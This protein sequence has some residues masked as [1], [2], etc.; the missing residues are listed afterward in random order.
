MTDEQRPQPPADDRSERR[1]QNG[2]DIEEPR[3]VRV[4]RRA[5]PAEPEQ[6]EMVRGAK[7]GSRYAR[8]IRAGERRFQPADATGTIRVTERATAPRTRAERFWRNVRRVAIG[9][10][11]SS[12][13]QESQRLPKLKA[14]AVFSSDALSSSAYATDEILLVLV[15]A[16]TGALSASI[17]IALAIGALLGIVAFSYRQ[18][19][20][21]YPNGG[22]SY[23]VARENLGDVAGLSAAAALSVDYI[24]T[25]SVSVAAGVFAITS[26]APGLNEISVE[27][28]VAFVAIITLL[29]LRG[30][31]ESGT[32]FAIPTYAFIIGFVVL[33]VG[34][35]VRMGFDP[36]LRAH[37]PASGWHAAGAASLSWF[38]VLRAFASGSAALT[39]VEAISN[40]IPAFKKPESKNASITL[41]WM[42]AILAVFF[43][44]LTIL[45]HQFGV[46]HADEVSAPAQV[47]RVV[48]GHTPI[49][50]YI[51]ASTA[52]ILILAANTSYADFPRLASILSRD[53]FLPHQ[54]TF[55]GDR[56]AFSN[57][58]I[59]L[60]V[61]ASVLLVIFDADV[62]R[63]IPLYAFGV[64]VSFTLSQSGM[65]IHHTRL[66]EPGWKGSLTIN[67]TGAIATGV[68]AVII[69]ATKFSEG[70]WISMIAMVVLGILFYQIHRHY[71][72]VD[73][74][75]AI[76]EDA[77]LGPL[78][79]GRQSVLVPVETINRATLQTI[80]YAHSISPSVT[81]LHVTDDPEEGQALRSEWE[82][83]VLDVPLVVIDSPFRSF[84]APVLSYI[85]ALDRADPGQF[86]TVVLPDF[87]TAWPWQRWLHNQSARRLRST[88]RE[89]PNTVIVDVPY[90][91]RGGD[92]DDGST[93]DAP[94]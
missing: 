58:I 17:P 15:A 57:G 30:L 24:L 87:V 49:F 75:L 39:G 37:E 81:A 43:I 48:Y 60:G 79:P 73:H 86:V 66:K 34:G 91:L 61:V 69:G 51:Q 88:L 45:A 77:V 78:P 32:I 9:S 92:A 50:Y 47:A 63:L 67:A 76:P 65:V 74:R 1:Q 25:V 26:A 42:V 85:D 83:R 18:T 94:A 2:R 6:S 28:S 90:H 20:R 10:P 14:L 89:R 62:D 44:G 36:G 70:A 72:G 38:L 71:S 23:I 7:P 13:E 3:A 21:A 53:R 4:P 16:G 8:L 31:R 54:F 5:Q 59:V 64:F 41:L 84:V 68:V 52:L 27:L 82:S 12:E 40:G 22:G 35:F 46:R 93:G 29:N 33:L 55:R 56:L 80:D 19:I 11:I